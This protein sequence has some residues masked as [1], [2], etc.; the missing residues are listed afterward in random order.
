MKDSCEEMAKT[1]IQACPETKG[2]RSHHGMVCG[3]VLHLQ[4]VF[5]TTSY[6]PR[7]PWLP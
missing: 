7:S 4:L 2:T 5:F 6:Y 1:L 3:A